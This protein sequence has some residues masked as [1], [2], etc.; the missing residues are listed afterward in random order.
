M[1]TPCSVLSL[2]PVSAPLQYS[3][4]PETARRVSSSD[5][6]NNNFRPNTNTNNIRFSKSNEYEYE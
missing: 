2:S 5:E 3:N 4:Y 1:L 6:T